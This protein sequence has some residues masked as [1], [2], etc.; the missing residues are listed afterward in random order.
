[1]R[2]LEKQDDRRVDETERTGTK[3]V[4]KKER[5]ACGQERQTGRT[6]RQPVDKKYR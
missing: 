1:M 3:P 5:Q 6:G 4:D 2:I